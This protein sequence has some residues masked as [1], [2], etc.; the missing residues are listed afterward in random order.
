MSTLKLGDILRNSG[1]LTDAELDNGLEQQ[2]GTNK[3]LGDVLL[4][5]G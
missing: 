5:L 2:R 1:V 4:E 3:F